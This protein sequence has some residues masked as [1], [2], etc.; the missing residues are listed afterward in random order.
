M[1]EQKGF[2]P[3]E[4][5][6][7]KKSSKDTLADKF[8]SIQDKIDNL[9]KNEKA[10]WEPN[11]D[12][13]INLIAQFRKAGVD[14]LEI[15]DKRKTAIAKPED[16]YQYPSARFAISQCDKGKVKFYKLSFRVEDS[17]KKAAEI[18]QVEF[19]ENCI[20]SLIKS[21]D[22]LS[23][24]DNDEDRNPKDL[25]DDVKEPTAK[26][27]KDMITDKDEDDLADDE[28]ISADIKT[29]KDNSTEST[30]EFKF[31]EE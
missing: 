31:K 22:L 27:V 25:Y 6:E 30:P 23:K 10:L 4:S 11:D 26:E 21:N 16:F 19:E 12:D 15:D 28:G 5:G 24:E 7:M 29:V 14:F 9:F 3:K 20:P 18:T 1:T 8:D 2:G 13:W 17:D